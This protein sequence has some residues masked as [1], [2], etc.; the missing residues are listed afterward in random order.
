V[1]DP[2]AWTE[3]PS[4]FRTHARQRERWHRGLVVTLMSQ[5]RL[6][7]N[8]RFGRIGLVTMPFFVFGEMLAPVIEVGGYLVIGLGIWLG[9]VN[10]ELFLLFLFAAFGFQV[11][12]SIWAVL[13]EEVTFRLYR[14]TSDFFRMLGYAMAEPFGYRQLTVAWRVQAFWNALRGLRSWGE[15]RRR[16][17]QNH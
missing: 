11:F 1:P 13:L 7:L 10:R 5:L 16:G 3:V 9:T 2:V 4:D 15:M 14:R 17:F 8:P 12:L 6:L